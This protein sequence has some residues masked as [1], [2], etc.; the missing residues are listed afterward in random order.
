MSIK[1]RCTCGKAYKVS[2]ENAG[3]KMVCK[4]CQKTLRVPRG[5]PVPTAP[6]SEEFEFD[7]ASS[8]DTRPI[9][10]APPPL[11]NV[12]WK[13]RPSDEDQDGRSPSGGR[14]TAII[15][16][17]GLFALLGLGGV[18]YLVATSVGGSQGPA[19]PQ[20]YAKFDVKN[21]S[22]TLDYPVGWEVKSKDSNTVAPPWAS[23]EDGTAHIS[24]RAS[25]SGTLI[26]DVQSA[27][28][29]DPGG[30]LENDEL[31]P[32]A[33]THN[34]Q[35]EKIALDYKEWNEG[36]GKT[37]QIP[38]GQVRMSEFTA[39]EG[40]GASDLQGYRVTMKGSEYQ[41][42]V[43]CKCP[44]RKWEQYESIFMHVINSIGH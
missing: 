21:L 34:Y 9:T 4:G 25:L 20:K 39:N 43:I 42:N 16:A 31:S 1:F 40:F 3:R 2:A 15:I 24:V 17:L 23:F 44:S 41:Y 19:E 36:P 26:N 30:E 8:R 18:G 13:R 27:G 14:K 29:F 22:F 33:Q 32:I 5:T 12:K 7:D 10:A 37:I 11:V 28:Q 6:E 38:F 35:A